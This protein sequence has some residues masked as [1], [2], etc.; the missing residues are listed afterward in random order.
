VFLPGRAA[1][2][3]FSVVINGVADHAAARQRIDRV[4][5]AILAVGEAAPAGSTAPR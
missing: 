5:E 2:L 4:V 3:A 1:P